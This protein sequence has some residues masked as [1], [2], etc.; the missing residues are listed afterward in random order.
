MANLSRFDA[1]CWCDH[2]LV[3][4]HSWPGRQCP[5]RCCLAAVL[6]FLPQAME[7]AL[8]AAEQVGGWEAQEQLRQHMIWELREQH[9]I[10]LT[11]WGLKWDRIE[12]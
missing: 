5:D 12:P 3:V 10:E 1:W 4:T 8:L 6:V 9:A 2:C 7:D 11:Q